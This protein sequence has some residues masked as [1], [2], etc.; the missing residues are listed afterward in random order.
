M[1]RRCAEHVGEPFPARCDTCDA[2]GALRP[3]VGYFPGTECIHHPG[4]PLPCD[5]CIR[6]AEEAVP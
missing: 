1:S 5:R 2:L 3:A 4:Y 6:D